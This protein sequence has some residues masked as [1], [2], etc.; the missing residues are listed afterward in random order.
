MAEEHNAI[1]GETNSTYSSSTL[2]NN[3]DI[4]CVMTSDAACA[5][6]N[7]ATS[8]SVI[9]TVNALPTVSFTTLAPVYNSSA[10]AVTLTGSPVGGT[11]SGPGISGN[12]FTPS[13]AGVGGPYTITYSY[14]DANTCSNSSAQQT[15]VA[16][17]AVP[18]TPGAITTVGGTSTVCPGDT[19][20]YS[21]VAVTGALS[22]TWT[23]PTGGT[24]TAGQGTTQITIVYNQ[25]FTASSPLKVVSNN[26]CGFSTARSLTIAKGALTVPSVITGAIAGVRNQSGVPYSVVN[27]AGK[28]YDWTFTTPN[29]AT[30]SSGNGTNSITADFDQFFTTGAL[31]VTATN[32]CGTS[33]PRSLTIKAG[34]ATPSG[35][36]GATAVCAGQTGVAYSTPAIPSAISYTWVAPTGC[37]ISDGVTTSTGRTLT[38]SSNSVTVNFGSTAGNL[39]V[40]ATNSCGAGAAKALAITFNCFA[41]T[42]KME[43]VPEKMRVMLTS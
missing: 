13:T 41:K 14:T 36:T 29:S 6:N 2:A 21:I 7:P 5:T 12:T 31:K 37:H 32:G 38:T 35:I 4:Q 11:F 8:S 24:I 42:S 16:N 1:S 27:V 30:V 18:R 15:R 39:T 19:K 40:K 17:C 20:S 9:M 23:P 3:D 25:S 43:V 10:S 28:T 26:N 34:P 33:L 22:Y